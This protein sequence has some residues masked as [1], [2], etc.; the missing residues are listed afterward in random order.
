MLDHGLLNI[1]LAK[2]GNINAQL[3]AYKAQQAKIAK[4]KRKADA[5]A[6]RVLK[7]EA[8]IALNALINAGDLIATKATKLGV[9]KAKLLGVLRSW[10]IW[11]P[12]KVIRAKAEWLDALSRATGA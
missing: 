2:R 4:A 11:E 6:F 5:E 1:P 3:D 10:S 9:S 12:A 7:A 8:K